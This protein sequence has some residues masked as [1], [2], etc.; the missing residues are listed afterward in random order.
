MSYDQSSFDEER[1]FNLPGYL[2][3]QMFGPGGQQQ[4]GQYPGYHPGHQFPGSPG[5][6]Q[7]GFPRGGQT[8]GAP[9]TP[10][11]PCTPTQRSGREASNKE[12]TTPDTIQAI[13]FP[14][15]PAVNSLDFQVGGKPAGR[16]LHHLHLSRQHN[17]NFKLLQSTPVQF[18][19][20]SSVSLMFG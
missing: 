13:N 11:P 16:L 19:A 4:G 1:Q 2:I 8:G 7:P 15:P 20:V 18:V 3:N 17:K 6:Q 14:A 9:P 10:P 12:D 5:G